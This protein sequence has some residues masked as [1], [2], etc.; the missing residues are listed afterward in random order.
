MAVKIVMPKLSLTMKSGSVVQWYKREGEKVEKGEPIVEVLT[1]KVTYDI[2]APTSGVLR[3]IFAKEGEEVPVNGLLAIITMPDE[4][5]PEIEV[6][7]KK[8]EVIRAVRERIPASPAAKRLAREYGIDLSQIVGTGP[9]GRIVEADVRRY[10]E[11]RMEHKPKIREKIPLVGIRKVSAER[12]ALSV[13]NA[14]H[15]TLGMEVDMSKTLKLKESLGIS[16]TD[17]IV[18][19]VALALTEHRM[20]NST[21]EGGEIKVF[22]DINIGVATA[23]PQGLV[24]P[25][26]KNADRKTLSEISSEI[27]SLT[28]KA[29][30]GKLEKQDVSGGTFTVTNL[31]MYGVEFFTPIINPPEAAILGVGKIV[32]KPVADGEEVK[33]KPMMTLSLSFDHRIVDGAPAAEFL[34]KIKEILENPT[35]LWES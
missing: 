34:R 18:K 6:K 27:K 28:Q 31:G 14:P 11:E 21:L 15:C 30:E 7:E 16:Y 3:K 19:A 4:V 23:T 9:G 20:L 29:R 2:E 26:V 24:V 33:I 32:K 10:I 13:K 17:I 25:V 5:L 1:E 35:V 8:E 12:V 22:E